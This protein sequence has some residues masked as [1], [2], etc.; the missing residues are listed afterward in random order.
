[1]QASIPL[2][3]RKGRASYST[4]N[5]VHALGEA[6]PVQFARSHCIWQMKSYTVRAL[7]KGRGGGGNAME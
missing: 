3:F 2:K 5:M 1:M 4:C 7:Q 6:H